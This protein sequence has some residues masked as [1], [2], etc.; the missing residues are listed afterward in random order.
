MARVACCTAAAVVAAGMVSDVTQRAP[1]YPH[2][3]VAI[4]LAVDVSKSIDWFE[5]EMQRDGMSEAVRDPAVIQAIAKGHHGRVAIAVTQ[6]SGER[7]QRVAIPWTVVTDM[8]SGR[9]LS[10]RLEYMPRQFADATNISGALSYGA[11]QL[12]ELPFP[13]DR[14]VIDVSGDGKE[15]RDP[16]PHRLRDRALAMGI[17]INGLVIENEEKDVGDHYER[18]I[19]GG[20]GSFVMR[21]SRFEDFTE[22]IKK[23]LIREISPRILSGLDK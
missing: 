14:K 13:A 5:Y 18:H 6:W 19:V 4:V 1:A 23:K 15:N 11:D 12:N 8:A 3:D 7:S 21:I 2:V 17:T 9:Q 10:R 22:A 20:P 16:A